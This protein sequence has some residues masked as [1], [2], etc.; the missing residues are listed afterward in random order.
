MRGKE[1]YLEHLTRD[2]HKGTISVAHVL[3]GNMASAPELS[4]CWRVRKME[5]YRELFRI[6]FNV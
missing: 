4:S 2:R 3:L 1:G 6:F 5:G